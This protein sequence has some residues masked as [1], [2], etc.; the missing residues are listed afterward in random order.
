MKGELLYE[1]KA[2]NEKNNSLGKE[3]F[4]YLVKGQFC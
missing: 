3:L 2:Q 1:K 4:L